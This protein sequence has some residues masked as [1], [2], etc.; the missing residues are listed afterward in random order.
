MGSIL[1]CSLLNVGVALTHFPSSICA[2]S[3]IVALEC[4]LPYPGGPKGRLRL[5]F[6]RQDTRSYGLQ[7]EHTEKEF[8]LFLVLAFQTREGYKSFGSPP[9]L[10]QSEI[11]LQG[12]LPVQRNVDRPFCL[13]QLAPIQ[14]GALHP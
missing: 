2:L 13:Q 10:H 1:Q 12:H 4:R 11:P 8:R 7:A 14:N 6:H 9:L 3:G 5:F